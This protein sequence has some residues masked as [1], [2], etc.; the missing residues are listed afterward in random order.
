MLAGADGFARQFGGGSL[1]FA[2]ARDR[3]ESG[4]DVGVFLN[5]LA[6]AGNVGG[7]LRPATLASWVS[8]LSWFGLRGVRAEETASSR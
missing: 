3:F 6:Q 2:P 7:R 8:E 1:L 5:A 4:E